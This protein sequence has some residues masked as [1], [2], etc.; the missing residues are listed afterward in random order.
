[1]S[2]MSA[3]LATVLYR[4]HNNGMTGAPNH[5]FTTDPTLFNTMKGQGWIPVRQRRGRRQRLDRHGGGRHQPRHRHRA[6]GQGHAERRR[7]ERPRA[8]RQGRTR[9]GGVHHHHHRR[10]H[11]YFGGSKGTTMLETQGK[12][13]PDGKTIE[14]TDLLVDT[15][16]VR[17]RFTKD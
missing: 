1:M 10:Q 3:C 14:G 7:G 13:S 2:R 12:L 6:A 4:L 5:R 15:A 9:A 16:V 11:V 8:R 17:Y